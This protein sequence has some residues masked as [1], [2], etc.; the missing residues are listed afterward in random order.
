MTRG[1]RLNPPHRSGLPELVGLGSLVKWNHEGVKY[2][3]SRFDSEGNHHGEVG[4]MESHLIVSQESPGQYRYPT[5]CSV[6][7][8]EER[9]LYTQNVVGSNPAPSTNLS[10][11]NGKDATLIK[12]RDR[13][14]NPERGR[15]QAGM[16]T[17][18]NSTR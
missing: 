7:S 5:P 3:Q 18:L 14:R 9:L 17:R 2:L 12:W 11:S 13:D 6:S 15:A 1:G 16:T 10:R 8:E 4:E